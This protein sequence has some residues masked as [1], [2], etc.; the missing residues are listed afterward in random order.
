MLVTAVITTH[1][2]A[3]LVVERALKSI[4]FQTHKDIEVFVV[5][6]SPAD[7]ELRQDVKTMVESYSD[8]GVTYIAH[9]QCK[10]ACAARNTGLAVANGE[11]IGYLDDDDEWLPNKIEEQ[12][13]GFDS[14]DVALVYC[15]TRI[16]YE[17]TGT[18]TE[19]NPSYVRGRVYDDL[20]RDNFIGSTS[21]PLIR[22][23]A[24]RAIGGFDIEMQSSQD[25]DVWLRLSKEFSVS[26][27]SIPLV[28]YH[29]HEGEQ[30]TKN[31]QK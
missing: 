18:V 16:L 3:P 24:L 23:L 17:S 6:D 29:F 2:R 27:V 12:L 10:G 7:Y 25:Y 13:K 28:L 9:E 5:D 1:K 8:K 31:P 19:R 20:M 22:T 15:G 30:I 26:Y 21:F 4:L 11:F 14:D